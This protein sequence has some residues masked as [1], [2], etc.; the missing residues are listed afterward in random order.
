MRT[1]LLLLFLCACSQIETRDLLGYTAKFTPPKAATGEPTTLS[2]EVTKAGEP[3]TGLEV[4][5]QIMNAEQKDIYYAQATE[6][7]G[8]YSFE[9]TPYDPGT[10]YVQFVF[11]A[12]NEI[13]KPTYLFS[14][15]GNPTPC[16][17]CKTAVH[18]HSYLNISLCGA[19]YDL[20]TEAGELNKQHT[21]N[22]TTKLHLHAMIGSEN[23]DELKLG[24]LFEQLEI[25]FNATCIAEY[26]N[27]DP[28][29]DG[30]K[31]KLKMAVNDKENAELDNYKWK[32]GDNI[33]INFS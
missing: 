8:V 26:C 5:G 7:N 1:I 3:V 32:D 16:K 13:L 22:Q 4:Q 21:H 33:T 6:N 10:H 24:N 30:K 15:R 9:W 18:W 31:G 12:E 29:P 14:V 11:R 25:P 23:D 19:Q 2:V 17:D 28:C 27:D 20:P